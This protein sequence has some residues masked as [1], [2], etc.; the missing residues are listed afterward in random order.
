M[1]PKRSAEWKMHPTRTWLKCTRNKSREDDVPV[2]ISGEGLGVPCGFGRT[3]VQSTNHPSLELCT[4]W[5]SRLRQAFLGFAPAAPLTTRMLMRP[6][7]Q[8]V[9]LRLSSGLCVFRMHRQYRAWARSI[10][11]PTKA[12]GV[13][14]QQHPRQWGFETVLGKMQE[15]VIR[16]C[17][18]FKALGGGRAR[19]RTADLLRVKQSFL[20]NSLITE[21]IFSRKTSDRLAKLGVKA[22]R[23]ARKLGPLTKFWRTNCCGS[24]PVTEFCGAPVSQLLDSLD[25][26]ISLFLILLCAVKLTTAGLLTRLTSRSDR[27]LV[28]VPRTSDAPSP[29]PLRAPCLP[30]SKLVLQTLH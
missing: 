26:Q 28:R 17:S 19:T 30:T 10:A 24:P 9:S 5:L 16:R 8:R 2:G 23:P 21:Q 4:L 1:R 29:W 18:S 6:V 20:P 7:F 11:T 27:R 14:R 3:S 12:T 25:F 13:V 22:V 15:N